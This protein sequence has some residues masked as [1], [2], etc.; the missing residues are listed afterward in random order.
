MKIVDIPNIPEVEFA[1]LLRGQ[2]FFNGLSRRQVARRIGIKPNILAS[3]EHFKVASFSRALFLRII[4]KLFYE[5]HHKNK[6]I[7]VLNKFRPEKRWKNMKLDSRKHRR[8]R[9]RNSNNLKRGLNRC[10]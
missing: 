10:F 7:E 3:I 4:D 6:A 9:I 8:D 5:Q 2:R 1:F